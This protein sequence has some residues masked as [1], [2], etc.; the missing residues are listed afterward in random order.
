[1]SYSVWHKE[2]ACVY[3]VITGQSQAIHK[4]RVRYQTLDV[5][6]T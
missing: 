4:L 1:M 6:F 3:L 2:K 5:L